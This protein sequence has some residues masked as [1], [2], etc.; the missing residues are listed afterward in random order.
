MNNII[1]KNIT[2]F[3]LAQNLPQPENPLFSIG[4]KILNANEIQN[5]MFNYSLRDMPVGHYGTL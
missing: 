2:E 1:F 4:C 5:K 3:N